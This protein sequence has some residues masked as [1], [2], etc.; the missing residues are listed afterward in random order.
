MANDWFITMGFTIFLV[1]LPPVASAQ[2]NEPNA[3][4]LYRRAS[5]LLT[6]LPADFTSRA[7]DVIDNGWSG[8]HAD[9]SELLAKNQEAI[10][11]FKNAAQ[12]SACDFT[13]GV[14]EKKDAST[15]APQYVDEIK[16]AT[17]VMLEGRWLEKE[18]QLDLALENYLSVL[19]FA[20]H[21]GQQDDFIVFHK[22]LQVIVQRL[23][24]VPLEQDLNQGGLDT[25]LCRHLL[26]IL[27]SLRRQE[28]GLE[29]AFEEEKEVERNDLRMV[30]VEA[31]QE[32]SYNEA[33]FKEM[34]IEFDRLQDERFQYLID[35][36][37]KNQPE[38]FEVYQERLRKETKPLPAL[39]WKLFTKESPSVTAKT[40]V[41]L[42]SPNYR[43]TI[44]R[45]YVSL[46]EFDCL[47]TAT[48]IRR[49]QLENDKLPDG[50]SVLV[51]TYLPKLP[52]DPFDGFKPLK[53]E[54]HDKGWVIYSVGP[55]R[56]DDHGR[57]EYE[58][59]SPDQ[60]GDVVI[61]VISPS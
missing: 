42:A 21:L 6:Q 47:M 58:E 29:A 4:P 45:Y 1:A 10:A 14:P 39:I 56:K 20:H 40:L 30:E 3:A 53:Y 52:E 26:D 15:Q 32:G 48:A 60:T 16:V 37:K 43:R 19:R 18:G 12:L 41:A 35:A 8:N 33:F 36:F 13:L 46:S 49:Y 23:A 59:A 54:K 9:L 57:L 25:R 7:T 55:D 51:P 44:N 5:S 22:L 34:Y 2:S 38:A 17:L 11:E 50:L 27:V 28:I 24:L 61:S 31:K